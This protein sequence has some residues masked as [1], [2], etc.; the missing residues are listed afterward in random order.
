MASIPILLARRRVE[1]WDRLA[2]V[3]IEFGAEL[4]R[5]RH[6]GASKFDLIL[7]GLGRK[8]RRPRFLADDDDDDDD[9]KEDDRASTTCNADDDPNRGRTLDGERRRPDGIPAVAGVVDGIE[10]GDARLVNL[11]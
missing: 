6:C 4:R 10:D 1:L 8:R 5:L 9:Q 7:S 3:G 11:V 2:R